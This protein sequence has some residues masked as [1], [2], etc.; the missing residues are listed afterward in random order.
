MFWDY[1]TTSK[2]Q[3]CSLK[4][5][6]SLHTWLLGLRHGRKVLRRASACLSVRS[7]VKNHMSKTVTG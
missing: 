5:F 1:F 7:H 2:M 3:F 6:S 4:K